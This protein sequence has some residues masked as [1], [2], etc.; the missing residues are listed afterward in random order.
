MPHVDCASPFLP[1]NSIKLLPFDW[2]AVFQSIAPGYR[3]QLPPMTTSDRRKLRIQEAERALNSAW[4]S[5]VPPEASALHARWW[6]L[7][8]WLRE[9][10]YVEM[11]AKYG[12][13]WSRHLA[14]AAEQRASLDAS[15]A[16]YMPTADAHHLLAYLDLTPLLRLIEQE[17]DILEHALLPTRTW[18]GRM[19]ELRVIRN[20]ISHCRRPHPDDLGRVEQTLRDLEKGAFEALAAF[21]RER[22]PAPN[23][24]DPVVDSW[25]RGSH[26]GA[27]RLI[28]HCEAQY[29][30]HFQLRY[31]IRPWAHAPE[32]G[33]SISGSAGFIWHAHWTFGSGH[34]DLRK[35]WNEMFSDD[36]K[37]DLI[38]VCAASPADVEISLPSVDDAES[39]ADTLERFFDNVVMSK[40]RSSDSAAANQLWDHWVA[41]NEHLDPRVAVDSAWVIVDDS[42]VPITIFDA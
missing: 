1:A 14:P 5:H 41:N 21:N 30:I 17:W 42:T 4:K 38:L 13:G 31:S 28:E 7:E 39:V 40:V 34:V 20:R 12:H 37:R 15:E 18:A 11:R 2:A 24:E 25:V 3:Q 23:L 26:I 35:L 29:D 10:V 32:P 36:L 9:L 22:S 8:S 27:A 16:G 6:Q 19:D 33:D